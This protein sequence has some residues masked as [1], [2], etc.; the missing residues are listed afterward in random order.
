M[1]NGPAHLASVRCLTCVQI[2]QWGG[3]HERDALLAM[4]IPRNG[5]DT[6]IAGSIRDCHPGGSFIAELG[7]FC[8]LVGHPVVE[9][10]A[11]V[12]PPRCVPRWVPCDAKTRPRRSEDRVLDR[13]SVLRDAATDFLQ[14]VREFRSP[15][16]HEA[17]KAAIST[18]CQVSDDRSHSL[19][20]L[21]SKDDGIRV[22]PHPKSNGQRA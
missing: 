3:L 1:Q 15:R 22:F 12:K 17:L 9:L 10:C 11:A 19:P 21:S 8:D 13:R 5:R 2:R 16:D 7:G 6:Q 14:S 4:T 20:P 18:R